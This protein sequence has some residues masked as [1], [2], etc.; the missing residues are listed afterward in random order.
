[1]GP[2]DEV[3]DDSVSLDDLSRAEGGVTEPLLS[4]DE[5]YGIGDSNGLRVGKQPWWRK[6]VER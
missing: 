3:E 1:M 2:R 6:V 4:E 5:E